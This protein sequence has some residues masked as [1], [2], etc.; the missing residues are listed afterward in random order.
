[1]F[2]WKSSKE[3]QREVQKKNQG[4]CVIRL[5]TGKQNKEIQ[6]ARAHMDNL[7]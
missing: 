6:V 1:M 7:D 5:T 4:Q 3:K 2:V